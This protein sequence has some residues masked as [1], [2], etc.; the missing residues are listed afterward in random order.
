L[1]L[2]TKVINNVSNAIK[3]KMVVALKDC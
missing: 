2:F 1:I 3:K